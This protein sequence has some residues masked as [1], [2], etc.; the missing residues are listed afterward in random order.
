MDHA[1]VAPPSAAVSVCGPSPPLLT[2]CYSKD[3]PIAIHM[4]SLSIAVPAPNTSVSSLSPHSVTL[5]Y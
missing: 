1:D 3:D 2:P 4:L 5:V